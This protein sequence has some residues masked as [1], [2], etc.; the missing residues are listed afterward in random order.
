MKTL[1]KGVMIVRLCVPVGLAALLTVVLGI[2]LGLAPSAHTTAVITVDTTADVIAEDGACSL[3]E[4]VIAANTNAPVFGP[5]VPM[6]ECT[7]DGTPGMDRIVLG[8]PGPY[9]LAIAGAGEDNA[10]TGDLDILDDVLIQGGGETIDAAHLD[11]VFDVLSATLVISDATVQNGLVTDTVGAGIRSINGRLALAGSAVLSNTAATGAGGPGGVFGGGIYSNGFVTVTNSQVRLNRLVDAAGTSL[12]GDVYAGGGLYNAGGV[13]TIDDGSLFELNLVPD[14]PAQWLGQATSF[15]GGAIYNAAGGSL[16]ITGS[17]VI[18]FNYVL[19]RRGITDTA[20]FLA[21]AGIYNEIDAGVMLYA[22]TVV[23]NGVVDVTGGTGCD[24]VGGG[25]YNA[26]TATLIDGDILNNQ[27]S[28]N[29]LGF[30]AGGGVFNAPTGVLTVT[31][32]TSIHSNRAVWD[33]GGIYN[34]S[35]GMVNFTDSAATANRVDHVGGG[36]YSAGVLTLEGCTVMDNTSSQNGGGIENRGILTLTGTASSIG[37]NTAG[38]CGG[39]IDN[40]DGVAQ[41]GS[42][43]V[44]GN[45]AVFGGGICNSGQLNLNHVS[46]ISNTTVGSAAGGGLYNTGISATVVF[47]ASTVVRNAALD[48]G[49]IYNVTGTVLID[50]S[51]ISGNVAQGSGG[52]LFNAGAMDLDGTPVFSNT[53]AQ[54]AGGIYN[55]AIMSLTNASITSNTA[56]FEAG[57]LANVGTVFLT[58]TTIVANASDLGGG[59]VNH[60]TLDTVGAIIANNEAVYGDGGGIR[61]YSGTAHLRQGR[62]TDNQAAGN[63][64]GVWNRDA[65]H[66]TDVM[67]RDNIADADGDGYGGGGGLYSEAITSTAI[68]TGTSIISNSAQDGGGVY[69]MD[70]KVTTAPG[71][72]QDNAAHGN[73]GGLFNETGTLTLI[74][75]T[76]ATNTARFEGG[77]IANGEGATLIMTTTAILDNEAQGPIGGGGIFGFGSIQAADST[78]ARNWASDTDGGGVWNGTMLTFTNVTVSSNTANG[79][80]GGIY[81]NFGAEM[82]LVHVTVGVN[83]AVLGT[84]DGLYMK[85]STT[86]TL[87]NSIVANGGD[88]DCAGLG[89]ATSLGYN[90]TGDSTCGL[91]ATGDIT[92]TD[93]L[94]GPLQDNGGYAETHALL[95]G[96]LAIDAIPLAR[97][98]VNADQRGVPRPQGEACDIGAYEVR[99]LQRETYLPLIFSGE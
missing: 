94:L 7:H 67:I 55:A 81:S 28:D 80:G 95:T 84:G 42:V 56:R 23:Q 64:G 74:E 2:F 29:G 52:G 19:E 49:G 6:G 97:C 8:L 16:V 32:E 30:S 58:A 71:W 3:R 14:Y 54:I 85:E 27:A 50:T 73:G 66:M 40:R 63:G 5:P 60:G 24:F 1:N 78:I 88:Q 11:R 79:R 65:L 75:T 45:E 87:T 47:S 91:A 44:M 33:G 36:I 57:G 20:C 41:V 77:G 72:V 34:A 99:V 39:G 22:S 51:P 10:A 17:S 18:S 92:N 62:I 4:A 53:S 48:G 98:S 90:L 13:A 26:G 31:A 9:V 70:G 43:E 37:R 76:V 61:N 82:A 83:E 35:G 59:V 68:L 86:S 25:L 46:I 21:G 89:A 12:P 96:S 69:L 15:Y 38:A 93:P